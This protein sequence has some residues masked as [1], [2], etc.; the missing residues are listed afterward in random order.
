M[1]KTTAVVR[2]GVG[3]LG[4]ALALTACSGSPSTSSSASS[5]PVP[6]AQ[7]GGT[8][9]I[10][11][12]ADVDHVDPQS[13]ALV[14]TNN[15][16]RAISR[17]LISY[18]ASTDEAER[19][20][21]Q[22]DLATEV[23]EPTNGGLTYTFT[24]R[25]GA[26]FDAP[27]GARQ[28]TSADVA[29]GFEKLCNPV[30]PAASLSYF[31]T[32]IA[33]MADYCAGFREVEPT[34][35]AMKEYMEST[36]ISGLDASDPASLAV[37]LTEP[38]G[39]FIYMVSLPAVSPVAVESLDYLPDSPE[40]RENLISSGP[41][42]ITS[43]V[44]DKSMTLERNPAWAADSDPLRAANV[45]AIE[46]TFGVTSDVALQQLQSGDADMTYDI[47]IPTPILQQLQTTGDEKLVTLTS[48]QV[49][50]FIWINTVTDN[51]GGALRD[52][53]V[54][55]ALQFGV[56]KAAVIQQLGG[57]EV[58]AVANG[59]FGPGVLGFKEFEPYPTPGSAGDPEKAKALL[60]EAGHPDG[61][62]LK[63]PYRTQNAEPAIAQ[64]IQA[65]LAK[66][67]FEVEL[68]PVAPADYYSKFMTNRDN[69]AA[70]AWDIAPVGW[71]PDWAGGSARSVFQPQFTF[72]GTPQTYNYVDYNNDE[73]NALAAQAIQATDPAEVAELWHQVD[74]KVMADAIIIPIAAPRVMLYHSDKVTTFKPWALGVQGD[75]TNV[76]VQS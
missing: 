30:I 42:T 75:W 62:K 59:I 25:E 16:L 20:T 22:G 15:L 18:Q 13:A 76:A 23:P 36:D 21:A 3:A 63:M 69:T 1:I 34:A 74:Q 57:P 38:A 55:Q 24:L 9:R 12:T 58:A 46:I 47:T 53:K 70:G 32:L 35:E 26:N 4:L 11:G 6:P 65:S 41:Y 68:V 19:I 27:S 72:T 54:R 39:D 14:S 7:T 60:A 64:T 44:A 37:T 17:Q 29:R 28:I 56:D 73:A 10:V 66:A 71:T 49:N 5:D 31:E 48:G 40:W 51:N 67:G 61:L 50:P 43:H 45:D 33:G 52:L 2:T 8:L